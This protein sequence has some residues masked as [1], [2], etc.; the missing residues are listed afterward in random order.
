MTYQSAADEV[1]IVVR[2]IAKQN[3]TSNVSRDWIGK[4]AE[5]VRRTRN[6]SDL[7]F[8]SS[9]RGAID[10]AVVATS[11]SAMRNASVETTA[12][13]LD[14]ALVALTGRVRLR[15]GSVRTA[16][17]VITEIFA[18]V[19]GVKPEDGDAGKVGAPTGATNSH[20]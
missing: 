5:M 19:F 20:S 12:I 9:V 4:V 6:H 7:R 13:G 1:E 17:E 2:E 8:G 14:S 18:D 11:L 3:S 10:T 15:E 16:E